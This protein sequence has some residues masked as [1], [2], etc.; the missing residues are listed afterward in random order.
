ML[1]RDAGMFPPRPAPQGTDPAA[2]TLSDHSPARAMHGKDSEMRKMTLSALLAAGTFMAAPV[3]AE[4][5]VK[6][7]E[8]T[9][10][11]AAIGNPKAAAYWAHVADDLRTAIA[12]RLADR[13]DAEK[14]VK[15]DVDLDEL[16]LA[17]S[18]ESAVGIADA[19]MIGKVKILASN[20]ADDT[21]VYDLTVGLDTTYLPA[22]VD[23]ARITSDS[24]ERYRAM[25]DAFADHVVKSI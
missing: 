22:G 7:I 5:L 13:L 6:E 10:D 3:W 21:K 23:Q 9:A 24:P 2:W 17:N 1:P 25:I 16:S 14:G 18:Y 12:A 11:V 20:G 15:V 4:T 8:V 19:R